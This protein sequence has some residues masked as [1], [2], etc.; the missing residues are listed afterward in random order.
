MA[1]VEEEVPTGKVLE[2]LSDVWKLPHFICG[3][4]L[5]CFLSLSFCFQV[6]CVSPIA[7][8]VFVALINNSGNVFY[9]AI[10]FKIIYTD[11]WQTV[12]ATLPA[13][14]RAVMERKALQSRV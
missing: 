8:A 9:K 10:H 3:F 12:H 7:E 13:Q 14:I 6:S 1:L 2:K 5:P 4:L 11:G